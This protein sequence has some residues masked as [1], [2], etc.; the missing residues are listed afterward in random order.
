MLVTAGVGGGINRVMIIDSIF[1]FFGSSLMK[2]L[3]DFILFWLLLIPSLVILY[4]RSFT[5]R[6]SRDYAPLYNLVL[7]TFLLR[8]E[9]RAR[10]GRLLPW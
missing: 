5:F 2:K 6:S 4:T 10:G 1:A 8:A 3:V 7:S 9:A